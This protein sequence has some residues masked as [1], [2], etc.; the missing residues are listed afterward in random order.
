[1]SSNLDPVN[2]A[3]LEVRDTIPPAVLSLVFNSSVRKFMSSHI[4]D[5]DSALYEIRQ[6]IIDRRVRRYVDAHSG[7]E[8]TVDLHGLQPE[9]VDRYTYVWR[10]PKSRTNG[11]TITSAYALT[12]G[13]N[14]SIGLAPNAAS[15]NFGTAQ[16]GNSQFI[17]AANRLINAQANLTI[18]QTANCTIVGENVIMINDYQ[19]IILY[20]YL[21]C[22][23]GSDSDF[24]HIK[25][26]YMPDF[27]KLVILATK[28]YI[29][30]NYRTDL[31]QGYLSGGQEMP[32][33]REIVEGY[34]DAEE[35]LQEFRKTWRKIAQLNDPRR[36]ARRIR[37]GAGSIY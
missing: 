30:N 26:H 21:R 15:A 5:S 28:A 36:M 3:L 8:V 32:V 24:S 1:M 29:Y 20:G 25:P 4:H 22:I 34:A 33:I 9:Q 12:Y 13:S 31:N 6:R 37:F 7:I 16:C 19:P 23:V 14:G 17:D 18:N 11:R 2:Y 35:M 27:A 10:I